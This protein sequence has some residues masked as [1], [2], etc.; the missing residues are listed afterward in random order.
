MTGGILFD[1]DTPLFVEHHSGSVAVVYYVE[2]TEGTR[3]A[4]REIIDVFSNTGLESPMLVMIDHSNG[5]VRPIPLS[6][7][8][9]QEV[10]V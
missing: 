3:A 9:L 8:R 5:T 6:F 4:A 1:Q 7:L 10:S 2:D